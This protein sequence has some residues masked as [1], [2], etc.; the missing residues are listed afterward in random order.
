MR[1]G[2]LIFAGLLLASSSLLAQ[3]FEKGKHAINVGIGFG[4]TA[5]FGSGYSGFIPSISSSYEYGIVK[6]PM[7]PEL[8]GVV[9][10][11]GYLGWATSQYKYAYWVDGHYVYNSIIVAVRGNY[12]FIFHDKLDTY[13]GVLLGYRFVNG[14]SSGSLPSDWSPKA[15]SFVPGLYVGG[16]WFFNDNIAAFAE[17][18][19]LISV[20]NIGVTFKI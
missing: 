3:A 12:H 6:V 17:L 9:S 11:G 5:Y 15:N 19:Y 2:V 7:G 13:A 10:V 20:F 18:G 16:R 4:N 14:R 8:N 1:K